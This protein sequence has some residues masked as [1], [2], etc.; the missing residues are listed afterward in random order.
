M[1]VLTPS[2]SSAGLA[3][4]TFWGLIWVT[5]TKLNVVTQKYSWTRR[6]NGERFMDWVSE[7]FDHKVITL[8]ITEFINYAIHGITNPAGVVFAI[9]GTIT[10][11]FVIFVALP[12]RRWRRLRSGKLKLKVA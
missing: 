2:A 10:N 6:L 4:S 8:M 5:I 7:S 1:S 3:G 11:T 12:V 9:G